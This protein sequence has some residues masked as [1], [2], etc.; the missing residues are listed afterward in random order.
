[1]PFSATNASLKKKKQL[2][3]GVFIKTTKNE[4]ETQL[5]QKK[6]HPLLK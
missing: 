2:N 4:E 3:I 5:A 6:W 1:L